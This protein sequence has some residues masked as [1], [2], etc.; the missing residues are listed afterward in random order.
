MLIYWDICTEAVDLV[1]ALDPKQ[2]LGCT[3]TV[4]WE[5]WRV[6]ED[7]KLCSYDPQYQFEVSSTMFYPHL[8]NDKPVYNHL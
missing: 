8:W 6:K 1:Y 3:A 5:F 2:Q 4:P 7:D